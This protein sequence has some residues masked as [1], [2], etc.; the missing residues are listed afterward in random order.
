MFQSAKQTKD[1]VQKPTNASGV[2]NIKD[3]G[4][5]FFQAKLTVNQPGDAHEMEAD[6]VADQVMLMKKGDVPVVQRMEFSP[7]SAFQRK[8]TDASSGSDRNSAPTIVTDVLNSGSGHPMDAS[9]REFMESRFGQDFSRVRVHTD[10]QAAESAAAINAK[11]YT[12]GEKIVF[13]VGAYQPS[14]ETGKKLLA[15]ELTHAVQ[16]GTTSSFGNNNGFIHRFKIE[17]PWDK[18]N[19]VHENITLESL[20]QAGLTGDKTKYDDKSIWEFNRGAIFNDD[21]EGLLFDNNENENQNFSS[22]ATWYSHFS[23][24]NSKAQKGKSVGLS[25]N[26]TARSHF[27]DLQFLHGMATADGEKASQTK[28]K[29]FIWAEFTYKVAIGEIGES[30]KMKD[31]PVSGIPSLFTG[32]L[33]EMTIR[34]FF[35][36]HKSGSTQQRAIGSLLH[37]IQDSFAE[38]HVQRE[39]LGAGRKGSI[40]SFHSYSNQD[41]DKHGE[42]DDFVKGSKGTYLE[43]LKKVPGAMDAIELGAE[44]LKH[45][46]NKVPW[47]Q[48]KLFLE[49]VFRLQNPAQPASAGAEFQKNK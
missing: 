17:G 15:H 25:D 1:S 16:Q 21:P 40:V 43:K 10:S 11:A 22:G 19:P 33:G 38:G 41:E 9:T 44:L 12:S 8:E 32:A 2:Q 47:S 28:E 35:H 48:T 30:I 23:S 24:G 14:S 45:Y 4:N 6:K 29:M 26:L 42:K 31:V 13:G 18:G 5:P 37:M 3:D 7:I 36:V 49:D 20:K 39:D 34:N 46:N 27:G